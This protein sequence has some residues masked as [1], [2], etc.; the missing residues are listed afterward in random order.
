MR[1]PKFFRSKKA[2]ID[3][4]IIVGVGLF[5]VAGVFFEAQRS[6][7]RLPKIT[8]DAGAISAPIPTA[9][10]G[11]GNVDDAGL[12]ENAT[13]VAASTATP[14]PESTP[15]P[16]PLGTPNPGAVGQ[17]VFLELR[18]IENESVVETSTVMVTG[19]TTPDAL[20]SVNGQAIAVELDGSFSVEL[21]LEEGPNFVEFVSSNLRGQETNRVISVVSVQ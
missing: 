13:A 4:G 19:I 11:A 18:G 2:A 6:S 10:A 15:E 17:Q 14:A 12:T 21:Q 8:R 3:L 5:F 20:L 16:V 1:Y 9:N 7:G